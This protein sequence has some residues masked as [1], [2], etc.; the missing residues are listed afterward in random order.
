MAFNIFAR[1]C[2]PDSLQHHA[3]KFI[4]VSDKPTKMAKEIPMTE[5][6]E[7]EMVLDTSVGFSYL[8]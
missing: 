2:M 8:N 3:S 7:I 6:T 1:Q 4:V 5:M